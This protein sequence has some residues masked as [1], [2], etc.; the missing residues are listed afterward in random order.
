MGYL[1]YAG[2]EHVDEEGKC[3]AEQPVEQGQALQQQGRLT[4]RIS[5]SHRLI[6]PRGSKQCRFFKIGTKAYTVHQ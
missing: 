3:Y 5:T 6:N 1:E 2:A 4:S